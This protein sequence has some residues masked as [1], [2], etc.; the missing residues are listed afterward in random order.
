MRN[1]ASGRKAGLRMVRNEM[2]SEYDYPEE[3]ETIEHEDDIDEG[4]YA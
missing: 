4:E 1:E 2:A 3:M